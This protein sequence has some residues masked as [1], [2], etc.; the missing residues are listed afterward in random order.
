MFLALKWNR[1]NIATWN[2]SAKRS[3]YT[4]LTTMPEEY[5]CK[6]PISIV[7]QDHIKDSIGVLGNCWVYV[8][9]HSKEGD[10]VW[11]GKQIS[12]IFSE[13]YRVSHICKVWWWNICFSCLLALIPKHRRSRDATVSILLRHWMNFF[14]SKQ[15][16]SVRAERKLLVPIMDNFKKSSASHIPMSC[17]HVYNLSPTIS[18]LQIL[19]SKLPSASSKSVKRHS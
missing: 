9:G 4:P 7:D 6:L 13:Q 11:N 8:I 18:G 3:R 17:W 16:W 1:V 12:L 2:A 14:M 15:F 19:P 5:M 10:C